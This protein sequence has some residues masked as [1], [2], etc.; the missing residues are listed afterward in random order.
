MM[1]PGRTY[2]AQTGYRYGFNGKENDNEVK[3]EGNEVA[4]ENRI[5]DPRTGRWLSTDPSQHKHPYESPYMFAGSNP[6]FY[7]DPDGKDKIVTIYVKTDNGT[8]PLITYTNKNHLYVEAQNRYSNL[9]EYVKYNAIVSVTLD[10]TGEKNGVQSTS[11]KID[12]AHPMNSDFV[13]WASYKTG[14]WRIPNPFRDQ[15]AQSKGKGN[16]QKAGYVLTG[17]DNGTTLDLKDNAGHIYGTIDVGSLLKGLS[18][19]D[20]LQPEKLFESFDE[21]ALKNIIHV[22]ESMKNVKEGKEHWNNLKEAT[23]KLLEKKVA[24]NDSDTELLKETKNSTD[25]CTVCGRRT[26]SGHVNRVVRSV[27]AQRK[28]DAKKQ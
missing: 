6:I 8:F 15:H 11:S 10:F 26:D 16:Y 28:K 2:S 13:E 23:K 25:S 9:P 1:M 27:N 5:Y 14:T 24:E 12:Y 21:K 7:K 19:F 4:F 22:L 17:N 18:G 20:A 3:G